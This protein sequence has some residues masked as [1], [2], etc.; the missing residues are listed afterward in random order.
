MKKKAVRN[1]VSITPLF[2]T[3]LSTNLR[4]TKTCKHSVYR[5]L[6][7]L[8]ISTPRVGLEPTTPRLTAACSTIELSRIVVNLLC[9]LTTEESP[10][11]PTGFAKAIRLL[12]RLTIRGSLR[13]SLHQL[14]RSAFEGHTLKTE[15][16]NL[17]Q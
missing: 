5:S 4:N 3:L 16:E 8:F 1:G 9:K 13:N 11:L 10:I 15:P 14:T 17:S 7:K 12:H 2:K 6:I